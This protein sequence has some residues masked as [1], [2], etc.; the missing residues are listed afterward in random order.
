MNMKEN[1][2]K[3]GNKIKTHTHVGVYGLVIKD[4][5]ILLIDKVSGPYDGKLDLPGGS[6]EFGETPKETLIREFSEEVGI[7]PIEYELFDAGSVMADWNYKNNLIK[8]HHIG[9][10]YKITK[11]EGSIKEEIKINENNDDSK[12]A[13]FHNISNLNKNDLSLIA[14]LELEKLGYNIKE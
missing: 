8:V 6:F 1:T 13:S 3:N 11:Y 5:Q 12:G 2:D 9:M 10:F 14:I 4:D 7:T